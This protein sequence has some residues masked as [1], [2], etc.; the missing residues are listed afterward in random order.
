VSLVEKQRHFFIDKGSF[1][2]NLIYD[3][4]IKINF[5]V[6]FVGTPILTPTLKVSK[7]ENKYH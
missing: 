1:T 5:L 7:N 6:I 4:M 3:K 2:S